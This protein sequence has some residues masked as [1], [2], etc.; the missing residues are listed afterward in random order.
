MKTFVLINTLALA[1]AFADFAGSDLLAAKTKDSSMQPT[2]AQQAA[3]ATVQ[4]LVLTSGNYPT[5]KGWYLYAD[6][7]YWHA[8]EGDQ[9]WAFKDNTLKTTSAGE[10]NINSGPLKSLRFKWDW[11][12]RVGLGINMSHDNWDGN[13]QYTRFTTENSNRTGVIEGQELGQSTT[14]LV[15]LFTSGKLNWNIQ[16][17]IFNAEIGRSFFVSKKISLRPHG[18]LIGGWIDQKIHGKYFHGTLNSD[19]INAT[20]FERVQNDFWGIGAIG[21]LNSTWRIG[22]VHKNIFNLLGDFAGALMYGH[23]DLSHR[24]TIQ[25]P[26]GPLPKIVDRDLDRSL[27]V[28]M[29]QAMLGISWNRSFNSDQC[30]VGVKIGYEFQFWFRQLQRFTTEGIAPSGLNALYILTPQDLVLQGLT[31]DVRFDF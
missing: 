2:Q 14:G 18:G 11:A 3:P 19:L 26:S 22:T 29:I 4:P 15:N 9:D 28:P 13:L 10:G 16:Y 30:F 23:F 21:G 20:T 8:D 12:F 27:A 31:V 25:G 7:L 24:T 17:S 6:A 5:N 1:T